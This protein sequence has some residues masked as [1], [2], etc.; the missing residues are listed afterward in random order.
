MILSFQLWLG[1]LGENYNFTLYLIT[2]EYF[3]Q[4]ND[5]PLFYKILILY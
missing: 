4:N 3:L 5:L 2:I 1:F